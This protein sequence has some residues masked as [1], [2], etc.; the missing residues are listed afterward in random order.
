MEKKLE[1]KNNTKEDRRFLNVAEKKLTEKQIVRLQEE[2]DH[3]DFLFEHNNLML[4]KGLE[5]NYKEKLRE[6]KTQGIAL[7][8]EIYTKKNTIKILKE[9]IEKGVICS[10]PEKSNYLG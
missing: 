2:L 10:N 8:K 1:M 4:N 5:S 3:L 7:E 9:Q 6:F